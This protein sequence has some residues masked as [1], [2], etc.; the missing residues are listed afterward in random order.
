MCTH[1]H[2]FHTQTNE[3][4]HNTHVCVYATHTHFTSMYF[5]IIETARYCPEVHETKQ[6]VSSSVH[7][8]ACQYSSVF[9]SK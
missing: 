9:L 2:A 3:L 5:Y 1:I 4:T 7:Q 8:T 6:A